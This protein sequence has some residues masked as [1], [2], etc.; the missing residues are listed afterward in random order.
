MG[1]FIAMLTKSKY[2][3]IAFMTT[4]VSKKRQSYTIAFQDLAEVG[5]GQMNDHIN[6]FCLQKCYTSLKESIE[7]THY[8]LHKL[9]AYI[10]HIIENCSP[11]S[12]IATKNGGTLWIIPPRIPAN[13]TGTTDTKGIKLNNLLFA[14][15]Q[16]TPPPSLPQ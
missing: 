13:E 7:V 6:L 8:S 5:W 15:L 10:Y 1:Y 2:S 3:I 9:K 16:I 12:A 14:L 11:G 4:S